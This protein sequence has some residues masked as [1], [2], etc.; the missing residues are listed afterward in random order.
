[1]SKVTNNIFIDYMTI[2]P[3]FSYDH[4]VCVYVIYIRVR[5]EKKYVKE[6]YKNK[7]INRKNTK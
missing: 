1:M 3:C 6:K 2:K 7:K 4:V 5:F